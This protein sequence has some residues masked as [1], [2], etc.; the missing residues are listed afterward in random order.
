[1]LL[2]LFRAT[3]RVP[4]EREQSEFGW[5]ITRVSKIYLSDPGNAC[6]PTP[7]NLRNGRD[8]EQPL[9]LGVGTMGSFLLIARKLRENL[10]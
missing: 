5:Q 1:M 4:L 8:H 3:V 7:V 9:S 10:P 6:C 2:S